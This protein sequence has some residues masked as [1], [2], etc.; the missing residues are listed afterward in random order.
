MRKKHS[1]CHHLNTAT[2]IIL[3]YFLFALFL[4]RIL[5]YKVMVTIN[6]DFLV[7]Y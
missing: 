2:V 6:T 4:C 5:L 7:K 1:Y 3:V